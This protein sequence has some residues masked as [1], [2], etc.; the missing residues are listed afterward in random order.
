MQS[1]P[2][3]WGET[4]AWK[5]NG[6][7]FF[8][9]GADYIPE[10]IK[11]FD[12]GAVKRQMS[13]Q[14]CADAGFNVSASGAGAIYPE[15]DFYDPGDEKALGMA[16]LMFACANWRDHASQWRASRGEI[17][18]NVRRLRHHASLGLWCGNNEMEQFALEG[19]YEG[20]DETRADYLIQNEYIIPEILRREDPDTFYWP[21]SPSSGG[22]FDDPRDENRGDVHYWDVWHGNAPFTAYRSYFFRFCPSSASSPSPAWTRSG[23]S[24][25]RRTA[26]SSLTSWKCTRETAERAAKYCS[27]CPKTIF[28]PAVWNCLYMHRSYCR[29]M[30]SGTEW[31]IFAA[32]EMRTDVWAPF[33]GS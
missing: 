23:P 14:M 21:S 17:A 11:Y 7:T 33:T 4:F 16:D 18:Q 28:I 24:R 31:N 19:E 20:T 22:K 29:Q 12:T 32:A 8:A 1:K 3:E 10:D 6:R 2:D 30:R 26:M 13:L 15:D 9:M 27:T 25:C 5:V